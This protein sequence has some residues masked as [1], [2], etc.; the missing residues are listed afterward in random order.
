MNCQQVDKLLYLYCDN[1]VQPHLCEEIEAHLKNCVACR[2]NLIMTKMENQALRLKED[3][4]P[5]S[6]DF[7]KKVMASIIRDYTGTSRDRGGIIQRF[8]C[9]V[10]RRSSLQMAG[11][12]VAALLL[13]CLLANSS[14]R[15]INGYRLENQTRSGDT[16]PHIASGIAQEHGQPYTASENSGITA[17]GTQVKEPSRVESISGPGAT[18]TLSGA[19]DYSRD[20]LGSLGIPNYQR[21]HPS[22]T[23]SPQLRYIPRPGYLPSG[24]SLARIEGSLDNTITMV[25][26]NKDDEI[27][28][29]VMPEGGEQTG[30]AGESFLRAGKSKS[31]HPA[32]AGAQSPAIPDETY[33]SGGE[34]VYPKVE[35]ESPTT[36]TVALSVNHYGLVYSVQITGALPPE[37]LGRI[38]SSFK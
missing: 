21:G 9:L 11:G 38:A 37:E 18:K 34:N 8:R 3:I 22:P 20:K 26:K 7:C 25:Y 5:T 6:P 16:G 17:G 19:P 23:N 31:T 13:F 29:R 1:Q 36:T 14:L 24:Y 32:V 28:I 2:N 30:T 35:L 33:G 4:P 15:S 27:T 10:S 12:L